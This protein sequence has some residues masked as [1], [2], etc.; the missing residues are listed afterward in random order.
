MAGSIN[1]GALNA[2]ST[3]VS[4]GAKIHNAQHTGAAQQVGKQTTQSRPE[5]SDVGPELSSPQSAP[6]AAPP[7]GI[8]HGQLENGGE[9][10]RTDSGLVVRTSPDGDVDSVL[11]PNEGVI[12]RGPEGYQLTAPDGGKATVYGAGQDR[13]EQLHFKRKDN[14]EVYVSLDDLSHGYFRESPTGGRFLQHIDATGAQRIQ[15]SNVY[16]DPQTGKDYELQH[17]VQI[18]PQGEVQ[19]QGNSDDLQVKADKL[20]FRMRNGFPATID[21]AVPVEPLRPAG[22]PRNAPPVSD[23]AP[24]QGP[25]APPQ[26]GPATPPNNPNG[27][28]SS[29]TI[30]ATLPNFAMYQR[31]D[32]GTLI[33]LRSGLTLMST[34]ARTFVTDPATGGRLPVTVTDH[35]SADGRSEKMFAFKDAAGNGYKMFNDSMDFMVESPD[36][37]VK[38]HVLPDGTILGLAPGPNGPL[39]F[40]VTPRAEFQADPGLNWGSSPGQDTR[41]ISVPGANGQPVLLNLPYPIP[42]DQNTAGLYTQMFGGASYPQSGEKLPG[43]ASADGSAPASGG[44]TPPPNPGGAGP[45]TTASGMPGGPTAPP[46]NASNGFNPNW[47]ATPGS[48][49]P[50]AGSATGAGFDPLAG[51]F[52][53]AAA[54]MGGAQAAGGFNPNAG[55]FNPNAGGFN[56]NAGGGFQPG[57]AAPG[58]FQ[59]GMGGGFGP[60]GFG[61][62]DPMMAGMNGYDPSGMGMGGN[63]WGGT[64]M[65]QPGMIQQ[66]VSPGMMQ[67]LKYMFTGNPADLA[68]RGMQA[69]PPWMGPMPGGSYGMGPGGF[70]PMPGGFN[71]NGMGMGGPQMPGGFNPMAQGGGMPPGGMPPG[72]MPP[73]GVPPFG[74]PVGGGSPSGYGANQPQ[75]GFTGQMPGMP[76]Q[77]PN[78]N[79]WLAQSYAQLQAT[80]NAMMGQVAASGMATTAMGVGGMMGSLFSGMNLSMLMMPR[81]MFFSPFF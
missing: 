12:K 81:N 39:R 73:G 52:N 6:A 59:P 61:G 32:N 77:M 78:S 41:Q 29:P 4:T 16:R 22:S 65:P 53:P 7:P 43:F 56:P 47:G 55:G 76:G 2:A 13:L 8:E 36:G 44:A 75:G 18:S 38:Q 51:G 14:T 69:P 24:P 30:H 79:A 34:A 46:N 49:D 71:P 37:R 68:P 62:G 33:Q 42:S 48:F 20:E 40:Q 35:V 80:N 11:L 15:T 23:G 54:G 31:D 21:Y 63:P 19:A 57:G 26:N 10:F 28:V 58:G 5:P 64:Y 72:G 45:T 1:T 50:M 17:D 60:G 67:R 74:G 3:P 27:P 25:T 9:K 70:G 66:P